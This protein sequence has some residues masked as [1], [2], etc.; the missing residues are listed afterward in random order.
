MPCSLAFSKFKI[1]N[2]SDI[3]ECPP[4]PGC[5]LSTITTVNEIEPFSKELQELS[6]PTWPS[7]VKS[8]PGLEPPIFKA[9]S[10][11]SPPVPY[12][13]LSKPSLAR[14]DSNMFTSRSRVDLE[15]SAMLM[16][17]KRTR[18]TQLLTSLSRNLEDLTTFQSDV[19]R[20]KDQISQQLAELSKMGV[21]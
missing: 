18:E 10:I 13:E 6:A 4:S 7:N 14:S 15:T 21:L 2:F 5:S 17:R 1:S 11:W 19:D 12:G 16:S 3:Q 9:T 8:P 20:V